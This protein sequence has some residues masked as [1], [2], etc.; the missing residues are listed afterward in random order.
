MT[1]RYEWTPA[2]E[3]PDSGRWVLTW[4][5]ESPMCEEGLRLN[6]WFREHWLHGRGSITHWRDV[7]PPEGKGE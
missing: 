1:P 4:H 3:P 5:N 7:E 2:S 6:C